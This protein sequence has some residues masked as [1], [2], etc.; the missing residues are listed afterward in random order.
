MNKRLTK[1]IKHTSSTKHLDDLPTD[2]QVLFGLLSLIVDI[3]YHNKYGKKFEGSDDKRYSERVQFSK[4]LAD[5]VSPVD[6]GLLG[7]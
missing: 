2:A 4:V 6:N 7:Y 1:L 5:Q 3:K